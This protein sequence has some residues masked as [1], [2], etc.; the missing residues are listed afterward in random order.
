MRV[1]TT[2]GTSSGSSR[3]NLQVRLRKAWEAFRADTEEPVAAESLQ[4]APSSDQR[5]E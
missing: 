5:G 2:G 3:P 4:A 1:A